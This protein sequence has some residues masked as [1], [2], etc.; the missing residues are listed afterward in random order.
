MDDLV[1]NIYAPDFGEDRA[2]PEGFRAHRALLARQAGA[3]RLGLS[4]WELLPGEAAYPYHFHLVDEE[5]VVV[6]EGRPSLRTPDGWRDLERGE[7]ASFPPGESGAHQL[8]NWGQE[9]VRFLSF[10]GAG[11][12]D[13]VIYPDSQKLAAGERRPGGFSVRVRCPESARA[14][15]WDGEVPPERPSSAEATP[16]R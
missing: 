3:Q 15:Y 8:V 6:L 11:L 5:L 16:P 10:S 9:T 14:D 13:I 7:I 2:A 4:L 12:P 1:A